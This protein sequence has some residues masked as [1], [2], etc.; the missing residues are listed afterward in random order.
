MRGCVFVVLESQCVSS[1]SDLLHSD[2]NP[3]ASCSA[4]SSFHVIEAA[5]FNGCGCLWLCIVLG[6]GLHDQDEK[7][8]ALSVVVAIRFLGPQHTFVWGFEIGQVWALACTMAGIEEGAGWPRK[9]AGNRAAVG[10]KTFLK[11]GIWSSR[12]VLSHFTHPWDIIPDTIQR[13]VTLFWIMVSEVSVNGLQVQGCIEEGPEQRTAAHPCGSQEAEC[14]GR[15]RLGVTECTLP[16][17][18]SSDTPFLN[19]SR[20]LTGSQL[21]AI[22]EQV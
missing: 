7:F 18:A 16:G 19:R 5:A 9:E 14:K 17:H 6:G 21:L 20:L 11:S 22:S 12:A 2:S 8:M 13:R 3:P 1:A 4:L 15:D 10:A